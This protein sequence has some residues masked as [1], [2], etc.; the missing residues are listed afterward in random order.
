MTKRINR[1]I[2]FFLLASLTIFLISSHQVKFADTPPHINKLSN[3]SNCRMIEHTLGKTCVPNNPERI[4]TLNDI[5]LGNV[6][7][8]G[9]KPIGSATYFRKS[10]FSPQ[11]KRK[12]GDINLLGIIRQPNLEKMLLL[13]PDL[14]IGWR[15]TDQV[16]YSLLSKIAPTVL[17]DSQGLSWQEQFNFVAN[18]LGKEATAT[19]VLNNYKQRVQKLK[20][21]LGSRYKQQKIS[22]I[23]FCC[24]GIISD[25]KNS[26]AGTILNDAGLQRPEAQDINQKYGIMEIP[27]EELWKADGDI[28]FVSAYLDSDRSYLNKL[29]QKPLWKNIRAVQKNHVYFVDA[30]AW[31]GN[32]LID[33]EVVIDDLFKYLI[34]P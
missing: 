13:K 7:T 3:I 31:R 34:N 1:I 10:K 21:Y 17:Y 22:L 24:N 18:T 9:V 20:Q 16:N 26:F 23:N 33:A 15:T 4:V 25:V 28:L 5:I 11:V 6:L 27:E 29:E 19:V 12:V 2:I 32:S 30:T 14:I 8:L